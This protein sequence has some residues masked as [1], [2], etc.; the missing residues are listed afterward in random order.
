[1]L[2]IWNVSI[3]SETIILPNSYFLDITNYTWKGPA[4]ITIQ[5]DIITEIKTLSQSTKAIYYITPSFCDAQVTLSFNALGGTSNKEELKEIL[6]TYVQHGITYIFS[7][8]DPPWIKNFYYE[9]R[10]KKLK[11]PEVYFAEKPILLPTKEYEELPQEIYFVSSK[12]TEIQEEI[13]KQHTSRLPILIIHRY[14][15]ENELYFKSEDLYFLKKISKNNFFTVST[16]AN[17]Q[18]VLDALWAEVEYLQHPISVQWESNLKKEHIQTLKLLPLLNVY[19]NL[20]LSQTQSL[21]Q[22]FNFLNSKSDYFNKK[23]FP[24]IKESVLT[25]VETFSEVV[26]WN[27]YLEFIAKNPN[28][29][30]NLILGS[31]AGNLFSFHGISSLQELK[32]F[33]DTIQ[34]QYYLKAGLE[35]SCKYMGINNN[36]GIQ[37]G[38]KAE[39]ILFKKNPIENPEN[40]FSIERVIWK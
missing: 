9:L 38:S 3:Y 31:G 6:E 8:F 24:K 23:I 29:Q 10:K 28:V 21:E 11:L 30:K 12:L 39:L 33:G 5:K 1:M 14:Y 26:P 19:K 7:I 37:V 2:I 17:K 22:E 35:N 27:D 18:S 34:K 16:F 32:L 20:Y 15:P 4:Q 40:L 25:Q 13:R 36:R